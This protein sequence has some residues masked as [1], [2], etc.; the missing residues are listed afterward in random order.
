MA[1]NSSDPGSADAR[2]R[3]SS[4]D[5]PAFA[6]HGF[7]TLELPVAAARWNRADTLDRVIEAAISARHIVGAVVIAARNG[8]IVYRRA[9]GYADRD[10]HR[11]MRTNE[12][13]RLASMTKAIVSVAALALMERGLLQLDDPVTRWLPEFRPRLSDGREPVITVRHL[14]T[15]TAGLGYGFL[16]PQD[17]PYHRL[18][19]SDGLDDSGLT[20][21]E[22]LRRIAAAPLLFQPG[23]NWHYS[24]A[25][26]VL[27]AVLERVTGTGLP[28]LVRDIVTAP[29][30]MSSV[31]FVVPADSV[32]A[33]P[34]GDAAPE[35][36]GM[37]NPFQLPFF[38]SAISYSPA[39]AFDAQAFPSGGTGMVGTAGDYLRFIEAIR[40]GGGGVLRP[41]SAAALTSNAIGN[42]APGP[43]FGWGLG[44]Q[45]LRD[46]AAAQTPLHAGAW[47]WGGVYGTHF[48]VDPTERLSL[49][50]LTNTAVAGMIGAFPTALQ[51]AVYPA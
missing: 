47:N 30:G 19:V 40:T 20:L 5:A 32:L 10:S 28:Q 11:P 6:V 31:R 35:P 43:G 26:D 15:H 24:V 41:Q 25:T 8:E 7:R 4:F 12:T 42:L 29:L 49:V 16:E 44:V 21:P 18:G 2:Q 27:G 39:R 51:Q 33:T 13:F 17:G 14:L 36:I 1:M 46:P 38:G 23:T 22:N 50:A 3:G 37:T 45:V 34:Y 48:W 9:A